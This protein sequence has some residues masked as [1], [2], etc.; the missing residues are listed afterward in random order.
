MI[1]EGEGEG[2]VSAEVASS[3]LRIACPT[4]YSRVDRDPSVVQ[5]SYWIDWSH[6]SHCQGQGQGLWNVLFYLLYST[7]LYYL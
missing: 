6:V 1:S 2:D 4:E 5:L 7:L 3:R